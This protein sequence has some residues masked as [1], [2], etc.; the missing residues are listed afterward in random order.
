MNDTL[1]TWPNRIDKY[2]TLEARLDKLESMITGLNLGGCKYGKLLQSSLEA[3]LELPKANISLTDDDLSGS[4][5]NTKIAWRKAEG[6]EELYKLR[7]DLKPYNHPMIT[8]PPC[9]VGR[10]YPAVTADDTSTKSKQPR[11]AR[12][13][14]E[15]LSAD[16]SN[17]SS[18]GASS[19]PRDSVQKPNIVVYCMNG[20]CYEAR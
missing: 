18:L 20:A 2:A 14:S 10:D 7:P 3:I 16:D 8:A 11:R 5:M 9:Y 19:G 15:D 6:L 1:E 12:V 17:Q 4:D 13:V